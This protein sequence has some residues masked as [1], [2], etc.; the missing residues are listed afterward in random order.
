MR[1]SSSGPMSV[2][3]ARTGWPCSPNTSQ[4][5][6][7][8]ARGRGGSQ[9]ALLQHRG[10]LVADRAGLADAGQVA[11]HVGHEDRHADAG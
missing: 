8:Q 1:A 4:S 2:T 6:A 9:A 10:Q 3:V 7:G 11:L 5:V